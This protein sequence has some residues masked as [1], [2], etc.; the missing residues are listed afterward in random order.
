VFEFGDLPSG[1]S[2]KALVQGDMK[3]LPEVV[4]HT[5]LRAGLI[6]TG[7]YIAGARTDVVRNAVAG[8][9]AI[10]AFVLL[11]MLREST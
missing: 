7:M 3:A 9:L 8:S 11:W 5:A 4:L 6:G 1:T 10:E 2:A